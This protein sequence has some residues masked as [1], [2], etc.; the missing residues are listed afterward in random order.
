[1]TEKCSARIGSMW[2]G[3]ACRKRAK[4]V[5]DGLGYCGVHDPARRAA[6]RAEREKVYMAR[7]AL[8]KADSLMQRLRDEAAE[9]AF[10]HC[11]ELY[12][13]RADALRLI[14]QAQAALDGLTGKGKA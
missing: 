5:V 14:D 7:A 2:R 8:R 11:G 10:G 12:Q 13:R 6:K 1:M 4:V 9:W 3:H